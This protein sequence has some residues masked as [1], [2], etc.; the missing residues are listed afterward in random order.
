[1]KALMINYAFDFVENVVFYIGKD[2]IRSQKAAQKIGGKRI[3]EPYFKRL[4]K[5]GQS[6]WTYLINKK[7]W[8][9]KK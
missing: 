3:V 4:I 7:E 8:K 5:E 9:K 6:D 2:N 1:M